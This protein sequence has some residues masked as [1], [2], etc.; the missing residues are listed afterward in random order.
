MWEQ[1][2]SRVKQYHLHSLQTA[3]WGLL[4]L[5]VPTYHSKYYHTD[6]WVSAK[7]TTKYNLHNPSQNYDYYEAA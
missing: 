2:L 3:S 6:L 4:F 1:Q 5:W 7:Q